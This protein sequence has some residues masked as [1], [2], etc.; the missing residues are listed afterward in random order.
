MSLAEIDT[1]LAE[2]DAELEVCRAAT[3]GPWTRAT[4]SGEYIHLSDV[5][6][7]AAVFGPRSANTADA[8][9][10]IQA[11]DGYPRALENERALLRALKAALEACDQVPSMHY[12]VAFAQGFWV[13][14]SAEKKSV[15]TEAQ[16]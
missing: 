4:S 11:R 6:D 1:R 15:V 9:L 2:I 8:E 16:P 3:P 5:A 12:H 13:A 14:I 10:V 7:G